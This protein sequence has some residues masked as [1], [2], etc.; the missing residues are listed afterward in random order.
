MKTLFTLL[1]GYTAI[2]IRLYNRFS[3]IKR[4]TLFTIATFMSFS[5]TAQQMQEFNNAYYAKTERNEAARVAKESSADDTG[6]DSVESNTPLSEVAALPSFTDLLGKNI[7]LPQL[8]IKGFTNFNSGRKI[9]G[10]I[11]LF[12]SGF[13]AKSFSNVSL[14]FPEASVYG[15]AMSFNWLPFGTTK[16]TKADDETQDIKWFCAYFNA[17]YLGKNLQ[18]IT[19]NGSTSDT[20][21]F[22]SDVGHFKLGFQIIPKVNTLS[23]YM[24]VNFLIP[25]VNRDPLY[26]YNSSVG[27]GSN[28]FLHFGTKFFIAKGEAGKPLNVFVDLSAV[29]VDDVTKTLYQTNDALI[30]RL[31]IGGSAKF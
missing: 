24:D 15:V 28:N 10:D 6:K 20:T 5:A 22:T 31:S 13:A 7:L 29:L 25:V 4:F 2:R 1:L 14:F 17:N 16:F 30:P 18:G 11:K 19:K 12:T 3:R 21:R 8:E 26:L 23:F 9:Y 27:K